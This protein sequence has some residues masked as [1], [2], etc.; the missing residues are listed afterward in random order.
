MFAAV[1]SAMSVA[2]EAAGA[3]GA[4]DD[5]I[6]VGVAPGGDGSGHEPGRKA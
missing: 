4:V 6:A 2:A 5:E 1:E 3:A